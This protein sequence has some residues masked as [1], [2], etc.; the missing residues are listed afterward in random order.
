LGQFPGQ[1]S[2]GPEV[3]TGPVAGA[4]L[5]DVA[6]DIDVGAGKGRDTERYVLF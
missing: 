5:C 1:L 4:V 2:N 6:E 3:V